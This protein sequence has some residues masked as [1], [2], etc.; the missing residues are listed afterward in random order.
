MGIYGC[1]FFFSKVMSKVKI[2]AVRKLYLCLHDPRPGNAIKLV[3]R[4]GPETTDKRDD[5]HLPV[6]SVCAVFKAVAASQCVDS[7]R[8]MVTFRNPA[9]ER[10]KHDPESGV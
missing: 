6:Q 4:D 1:I 2:T 7:S 9:A 3:H 8:W 5:F 10:G